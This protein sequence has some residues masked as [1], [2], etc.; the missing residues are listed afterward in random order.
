MGDASG[1]RPCF[2]TYL[3]ALEGAKAI[4][5]V[6]C[7]RAIKQAGGDPIGRQ[8]WFFMGLGDEAELS[9]LV[10]S[11]ADVL[12]SLGLEEGLGE[13]VPLRAD[14]SA[15]PAVVKRQGGQETLCE[16]ET[17]LLTVL[18]ALVSASVP[19]ESIDAL[20]ALERVCCTDLPTAIQGLRH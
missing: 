2:P 17:W 6:K 10:R 5:G 13:P 3:A 1:H 19:G 4:R 9:R 8:V 12:L 7:G 11:R 18:S 16:A 20:H 15:L 14:V